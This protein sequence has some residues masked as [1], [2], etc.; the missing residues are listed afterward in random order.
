MVRLKA[1]EQPPD[2][3]EYLETV[4][5]VHREDGLHKKLDFD[6]KGKQVDGEDL[7]AGLARRRYEKYGI[8]HED[9]HDHLSH[10][11]DSDTVRIAVWPRIDGDLTGD[12]KPTNNKIMAAPP[13][14]ENQMEA[15]LQARSAVIVALKDLGAVIEESPEQAL[16]VNA[17]LSSGIINGLRKSESIGGIY[18][19]KLEGI[20]TLETPWLLL[21]QIRPWHLATPAQVSA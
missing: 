20:L 9:L 16:V 8:L 17:S 14:A 15:A 5:A 7:L 1:G 3:Y 4:K 6:E 13:E 21:K 2:G 19:N 10:I 11:N 18:L 12:E